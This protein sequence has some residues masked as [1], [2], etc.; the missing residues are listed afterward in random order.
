MTISVDTNNFPIPIK[1]REDMRAC[2]TF[3]EYRENLTETIRGREPGIT[4]NSDEHVA[5]ELYIDN[6]IQVISL[7]K[8]ENLPPSASATKHGLESFAK[9]GV[10]PSKGAFHGVRLDKHVDIPIAVTKND[11]GTFFITDGIHR[12]TQAFVSDDK[13]ILAFVEGGNGPT[14]RDIFSAAKKNSERKHQ[15]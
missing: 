8:I 5:P 10:E 4:F 3:D 2:A 12:A 9:S 11:N 15:T 6:P 1:M 7:D 14:L 13:T